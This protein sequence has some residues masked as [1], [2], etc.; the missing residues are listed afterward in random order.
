MSVK[1]VA[2]GKDMT[3]K[4]EPKFFEFA[5][6]NLKATDYPHLPSTTIGKGENAKTVPV[7]KIS[8]ASILVRE[9]ES[10]PQARE[11]AA[12]KGISEERFDAVILTLL[13]DAERNDSVKLARTRVSD[14]K[15]LPANLTELTNGIADEVN[16]FAEAE[17][18]SGRESLKVKQDRAKE[19]AVQY[20]GDPATLAAKLMEVFGVA[21]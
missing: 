16:I 18:K 7:V 10:V 5:A 20:A 13:N 11:F 4:G 2:S 15:I 1:L 21:V 8:P 17:A 14:A 9:Y 6:S 12:S 19:L 3:A